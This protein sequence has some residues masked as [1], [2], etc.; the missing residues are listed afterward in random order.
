MFV[1]SDLGTRRTCRARE[2]SLGPGTCSPL[3]SKDSP[4]SQVAAGTGQGHKGRADSS[5]FPLSS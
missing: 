1:Q 5:G 3:D 4:L 2:P